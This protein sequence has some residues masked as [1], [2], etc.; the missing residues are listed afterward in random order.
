M[1]EPFA[2]AKDA[3]LEGIGGNIGSKRYLV[4]VGA[5]TPLVSAQTGTNIRESGTVVTLVDE[6]S[7]IKTPVGAPRYRLEKVLTD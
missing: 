3:R 6:I 5:G 2:V 1:C 4:L 7:A